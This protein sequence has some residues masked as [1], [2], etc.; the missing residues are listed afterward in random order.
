MVEI[1]K[2][3]NYGEIYAGYIYGKISFIEFG[4]HNFNASDFCVLM[5]YFAS[6][7]NAFE[8][9]LLDYSTKAAD[10]TKLIT[11]V[12]KSM[13][14]LNWK[15]WFDNLRDFV[16][17]NEDRFIS[18]EEQLNGVL[19]NFNNSKNSELISVGKYDIMNTDFCDFVSYVAQGGSEG[20][21]GLGYRPSFAN[22]TLNSMKNSKNILFNGWKKFNE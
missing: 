9:K 17:K 22:I 2:T 6:R 12:K 8:G 11:T 10:K 4:E 3:L 16:D 7:S 13:D 15:I 20:I 1:I 19:V 5:R 14:I 21:S 18:L